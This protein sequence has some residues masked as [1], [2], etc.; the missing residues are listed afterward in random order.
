MLIRSDRSLWRAHPPCETHNNSDNDGDLYGSDDGCYENVVEFLSTGHHVQDV[1]VLDFITLLASVA[2]V[3]PGETTKPLALH[4]MI[5][6]LP[7]VY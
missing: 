1:E 5:Q 4:F 2:R 7:G 3:T 6:K